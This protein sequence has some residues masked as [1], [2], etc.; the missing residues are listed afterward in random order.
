MALHT[1]MRSVHH[2]QQFIQLDHP[3]LSQSNLLQFSFGKPS[4]LFLRLFLLIW[5]RFGGT[6]RGFYVIYFFNLFYQF[7]ITLW[8]NFS[9]EFTAATQR[10]SSKK[11]FWKCA[12]NYRRTP[13]PKCDFN[14]A[15][16]QLYSN[17]TLAWVLF[18]KFAGYIQNTFSHEHFWKA[19][20]EFMI[21]SYKTMFAYVDIFML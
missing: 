1:D 21:D 4:N 15:A 7:L 18:C 16:L 6:Q 20:S 9:T 5:I 13:I 14:K 2:G 8:Q 17:H 10:C 12:E 11:V 19:A 3:F